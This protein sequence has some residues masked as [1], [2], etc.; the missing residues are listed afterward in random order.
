MK[1][2]ADVRI[3][4]FR[5]SGFKRTSLAVVLACARNDH[6]ARPSVCP[7]GCSYPESTLHASWELSS[8]RLFPLLR[9][10][11]EIGYTTQSFQQLSVN[12]NE[13]LSRSTP[14][15]GEISPTLTSNQVR[16]VH[17]QIFITSGV[18]INENISVEIE[19]NIKL[20]GL[21]WS[22]RTYEPP[23]NWQTKSL[24]FVILYK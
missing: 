20:L 17:F 5:R 1:V 10:I 15:K 23:M 9:H 3:C 11:T 24:K 8:H 14:S 19:Q 16:G 21:E 13:G 22:S 12:N 4:I 7:R 6:A 2:K 18:A